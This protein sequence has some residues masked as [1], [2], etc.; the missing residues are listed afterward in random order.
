[1]S[2]PNSNNVNNVALLKGLLPVCP[3]LSGILSA[4]RAA[5][6]SVLRPLLQNALHNPDQAKFRRFREGNPK[7]SAALAASQQ[8][9]SLCARLG[10]CAE[11][12]GFARPMAE[13]LQRAGF[14][15]VMEKGAGSEVEEAVW[16]LPEEM[17]AAGVDETL[18]NLRREEESLG[19]VLSQIDILN[20]AAVAPG[21]ASSSSGGVKG[22]HHSSTRSSA[23]D[24]AGRR[25]AELLDQIQRE[26]RERREATSREQ[27]RDNVTKLQIQADFDEGAQ[28]VQAVQIILHKTGRLRNA[29]FGAQGMTV[30]RMTA[31]RRVYHCGDARCADGVTATS[32]SSE[33]KDFGYEVHWHQRTGNLLYS[34]VAHIS[35]DCGTVWHVGDEYG[36]QYCNLPGETNFGKTVLL[37]IKKWNHTTLS[38]ESVSHFTKPVSECVYCQRSFTNDLWL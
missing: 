13:W 9:P 19:V 24:D 16:M 17:P 6:T 34:F 26:Q 10:G 20:R 23:E 30:S 2:T 21:A 35:P 4:H 32:D 1:M 18:G 37:N 27:H 5:H 15:R 3:E 8:L 36:Y 33:P 12:L 31:G 22:S 38:V 14:K 11:L 7:I 28:V 29:S 25:K